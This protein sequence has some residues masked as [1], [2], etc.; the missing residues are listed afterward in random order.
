MTTILCIDPGPQASG[1]C[2]WAEDCSHGLVQ[3]G[4][5][6]NED[7]R[8]RI[9]ECGPAYSAIIA[10]DFLPRGQALG[11]DAAGT[12]RFIGALEEM[13]RTLGVE[14]RAVPRHEVLLNL[15]GDSKASKA[16]VRAVLIDRFA[17]RRRRQMGNAA[18]R[19]S[20]EVLALKGKRCPICKGK[21]WRGAGRPVCG[22]CQGDGWAIEPGPMEDVGIHARDAVALALWWTAADR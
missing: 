7:L 8:D 4:H 3:A 11:H 15:T 6:S 17:S 16:A 22:L 13:A 19:F 1:F 9:Q 21:G 12:I 10:E 2:V 14:W 18:D 20:N 5:V